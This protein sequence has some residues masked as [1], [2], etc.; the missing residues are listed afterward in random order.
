LRRSTTDTFEIPRPWA[1]ASRAA[2]WLAALGLAACQDTVII[3]HERPG[4]AVEVT[5]GLDAGAGNA[6]ADA[7]SPPL[8]DDSDAEDDEDDDAMDG[9]SANSNDDEEQSTSGE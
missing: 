3:G 5:A 8:N 1:Y 6:T 2:R 7:Q 4:P 9:D